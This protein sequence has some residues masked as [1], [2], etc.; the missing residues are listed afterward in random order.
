MNMKSVHK[1]NISIVIISR[2]TSIAMFDLNK[3][4]LFL[5]IEISR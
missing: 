4:Q 5:G 3:I 1:A 2:Q